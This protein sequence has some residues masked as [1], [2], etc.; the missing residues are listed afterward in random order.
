MLLQLLTLINGKKVLMEVLLGLLLLMEEIMPEQQ[1]LILQ[2]TNTDV[3]KLTYRY[4]VLV[5]NIGYACDPTTLSAEARY[6]APS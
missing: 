2:V 5:N 3:S 4:R 1:Q 6:I